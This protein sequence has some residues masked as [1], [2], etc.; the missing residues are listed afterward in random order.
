MYARVDS[1]GRVTP[2]Y[3]SFNAFGI[4]SIGGHHDAADSMGRAISYP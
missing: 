1:F 2:G 3:K 4:T